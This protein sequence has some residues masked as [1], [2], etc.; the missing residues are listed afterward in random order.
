MHGTHCI[1]VGCS[2]Y[3]PGMSLLSV[4]AVYFRWL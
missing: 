2:L 1:D 4:A 3:F